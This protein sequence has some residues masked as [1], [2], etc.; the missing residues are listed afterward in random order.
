[1]HFIFFTPL[2][3]ILTVFSLLLT[4]LACADDPQLYVSTHTEA[5]SDSFSLYDLYKSELTENKKGKFT[6][7]FLT[8]ESGIKYGRFSFSLIKRIDMYAHYN[9]DTS[10]LIYSSKSN[11]D[12]EKNK[13]FDVD[14]AVD[15][16]ESKGIKLVYEWPIS[17]KLDV[18]FEPQFIYADK[19]TEGTV[20]GVVETLNNTYEG[21]LKLDYTYTQDAI[22][23]RE[24][25]SH[26][27]V[28]S[29]LDISFFWK[30]DKQ[31]VFSI[32]FKDIYHSVEWGD[33]TYTEADLSRRPIR[34]DDEGKINAK[35]SLKGFEGNRSYRISLPTRA[36]FGWRHQFSAASRYGQIDL[37]LFSFSDVYQ[38]FTA[39]YFLKHRPN[40]H[41]SVNTER[42]I[43]VGYKSTYAHIYLSSDDLRFKKANSFSSNLSFMFSF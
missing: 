36:Y 26:K 13:R 27:G 19:V 23:G 7:A 10:Q 31:N 17:T 33:L 29:A 37:S 22:L 25:E 20:K 42:A 32:R 40:W 24:P 11:A 35:A 15:H 43:G 14:L 5:Y 38:K 1:M 39:T 8:I 6:Y 34:Y 16:I 4:T 2:R 9:S 41:F 30:K 12:I 18:V 21:D 3:S 28:G